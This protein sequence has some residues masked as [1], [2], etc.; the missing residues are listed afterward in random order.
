MVE[1]ISA[2][3]PTPTWSVPTPIIASDL[4]SET[5]PVS[6]PMEPVIVPGSATILLAEV[7]I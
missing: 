7:A 2:F 6:T 1:S 3:L 5:L 4:P